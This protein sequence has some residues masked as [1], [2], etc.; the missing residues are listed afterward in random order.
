[1]ALDN[2]SV[3]SI[4]GGR[5]LWRATRTLPRATVTDP[6]AAVAGIASPPGFFAALRANGW[7]VVAELPFRDHHRY[8]AADMT[9]IAARARAAG[10]RRIVTTEK[11]LVRLLPFRPFPLPI[12]AVPLTLAIDDHASLVAWLLSRVRS[13]R[14]HANG[15]GQGAPASE[16]VGGTGGAKPPG[17]E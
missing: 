11:D 6:V 9:S 8:S 15:A 1:V 14:G 2:A 17:K 5:P 3:D 12:E 16:R 13:A 10:A 7:N 4:A